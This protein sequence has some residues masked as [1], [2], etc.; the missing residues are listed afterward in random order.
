MV[1]L[2]KGRVEI[3]RQRV[4]REPRSLACGVMQC[5]CSTQPGD[6]GDDEG[7]ERDERE[8][9]EEVTGW[10]KS[11]LCFFFFFVVVLASSFAFIFI[12]YFLFFSFLFSF[13]SSRIVLDPCELQGW[14]AMRA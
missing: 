1:V 13:L 6:E 8:R 5:S 11:N 7:D 4:T 9:S 12:Y 2:R 10:I 3:D 14:A